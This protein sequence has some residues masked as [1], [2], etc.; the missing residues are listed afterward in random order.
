MFNYGLGLLG[1]KFI[2]SRKEITEKAKK[3][4]DM[5]GDLSVFITSFVPG[6]PFD[7]VAIAVG[8]FRMN[9]KVFMIAMSLGKILKHAIIIYGTGL[10]LKIF[11][12]I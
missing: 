11:L 4:L 1:S 9:F 10:F 3:W 5:W 6:F 8:I 2:K 12:G 7:V